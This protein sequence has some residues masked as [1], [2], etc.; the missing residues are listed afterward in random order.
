MHK[1]AKS[2]AR[3]CYHKGYIDYHQIPLLCYSIERRASSMILFPP[4]LLIGMSISEMDVVIS[5]YFSFCFL[6][7]MTSG[8]HANSIT[9]CFLASVALE[10]LFVGVFQRTVCT[11]TIWLL[12]VFSAILIF[13]LAPFRHPNMAFTDEEILACRVNARIRLVLVLGVAMLAWCYSYQSI[14]VGI[15]LGIAASASS[16]VIASIIRTGVF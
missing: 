11:S 4:L 5:F 2:V 9:K 6:R 10:F 12:A 15:S 7:K 8:L 1:W 16:L 14:M 13:W 3:Y